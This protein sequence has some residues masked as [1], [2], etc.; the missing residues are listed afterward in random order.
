MSHRTG[1]KPMI[2]RGRAAVRSAGCLILSAVVSVSSSRAADSPGIMSNK[3]LQFH[4]VLMGTVC[5]LG[6]CQQKSPTESRSNIYFAPSGNIYDYSRS[7]MGLELRLG[8]WKQQA[9]GSRGRWTIDGGILRF[10][11]IQYDGG[12][13][14]E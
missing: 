3:T 14:L 7:G 10:T 8:E 12:D 1:D 9:D 6:R 13:E 2:G 4:F 5:V 11:M